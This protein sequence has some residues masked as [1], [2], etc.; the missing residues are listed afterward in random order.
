M[1]VKYDEVPDVDVN[2]EQIQRKEM[3]D[4]FFQEVAEIVPGECWVVF[5]TP[6]NKF[7]EVFAI[8]LRILISST[9]MRYNCC[10]RRRRTGRRLW[11]PDVDMGS[12]QATAENRRRG[13][14][15]VD[16]T[17]TTPCLLIKD[18]GWR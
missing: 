1:I 5:Q 12:R 7:D 10:W 17:S 14:K 4:L 11:N 3:P 18:Y 9:M 16:G 6:P 8:F 2:K 13:C 15:T